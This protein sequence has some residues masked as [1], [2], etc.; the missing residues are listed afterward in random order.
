MP[1]LP[2][3]S[4][5]GRATAAV[6]TLALLAA[7][8]AAPAALSARADIEYAVFDPSPAGTVFYARAPVQWRVVP[9][10]GSRVTDFSLTINDQRVDAAYDAATGAVTHLPGS[11]LPPGVHRVRALVTLDGEA[12]ID[13]E[14]E[15]RVD[16]RALPT[17]PAPQPKQGAVLNAVNRVRQD[18]G[19][20]ALRPDARLFAA[21]Q[22]HAEYLRR[23]NA[24]GHLQ[25]PGRPGF[26]GR[27]PSDRARA[28]GYSGGSYEDV[29]QGEP[30]PVRAGQ[31]VFDAPYHR[32]PFLQLGDF[33]VGAGADG[34]RI[35][36]LF[37]M[38]RGS[39]IVRFPGAG[40]KNV[41]LSWDGNETPDPLR[42]HRGPDGRR[43]R[44][45]FGYPITL[46]VY[47]RGLTPDAPKV[48]IRSAL[49]ATADG[50][51]VPAY[52]NTAANDEALSGGSVL[53]IPHAPLKPSTDYRVIA[54]LDRGRT[55]ETLSWWFR[56]AGR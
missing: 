43:P 26:L 22:A 7:L 54:E 11:A 41:P 47:D 25:V 15:F 51:V 50:R 31:G 37:G 44:G 46:F 30:D 14:W 28:F 20:P 17:L 35:T 48:R 13:R 42:H 16:R 49:L 1:N 39:G 45:P 4:R 9:L 21:A 23:N 38:G 40:Q 32:E 18:A 56:T 6:L 12:N 52:V 5:T 24:G 10:G 36:V 29:S 34:D 2:R 3:K 33:E 19:L 8:G 53:L 55:T 27:Q